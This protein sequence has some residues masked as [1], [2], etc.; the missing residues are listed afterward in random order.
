MGMLSVRS[1][2]N[3]SK[4]FRFEAVAV[5]TA[6]ADAAA[7]GTCIGVAEAL[8]VFPAMMFVLLTGTASSTGFELPR[9][10]IFAGWAEGDISGN[11]G[12]GSSE[13]CSKENFLR[14]TDLR[15]ICWAMWFNL[16]EFEK[17]L[18]DR[19]SS[20]DLMEIA[21]D[22]LIESAAS[23][24]RNFDGVIGLGSGR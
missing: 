4:E 6:G 11:A 2:L 14:A 3:D 12:V 18:D 20:K 23:E 17:C 8:S 19:K 22:F 15:F 1:S 5:P 13:P 10:G 21:S 7:I 16:G 9:T 24:F